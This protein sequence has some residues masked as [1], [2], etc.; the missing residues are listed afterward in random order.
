[1]EYSVLHGPVFSVLELRLDQAD[2]VVAQPDSMLSMTS[3][4]QL[5]AA[6]GRRGKSNSWFSGAKSILGGE[7]MF[8]AE[9]LAKKDGQILMLA[10]SVQGDILSIKLSEHSGVYIT[11]GGYLANIGNCNLQI[12][13]GGMKGMMSKKGLFLL[14]ASGDGTVFCQ[15]HGAIIEKELAEGENFFL[16]NR[17]ALAFSDTIT[18]RLVKATDS[19]KDAIMSGEGLVIRYTGPGKLYY[20][21]RGKAP[22][23]FLSYLFSS[24]F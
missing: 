24:S 18:Y 15:T 3:G 22:I 13:Y 4:L 21:T 19:V 14:H 23:N 9:F 17:Y 1:M 12:K 5:T 11:R 8:T 16:D 7:S 2:L 6:V 10:P 20:Q